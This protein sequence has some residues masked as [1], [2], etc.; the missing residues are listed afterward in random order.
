MAQEAPA[1]APAPAATFSDA[2]VA[3]FA[4]A[5]VKVQVITQQARTQMMQ[6]IESTEGLSIDTYNNIVAAAQKDPAL[7]EKISQLMRDY[8][9]DAGIS[10]GETG[11]E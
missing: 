5:A 4:K 11:T 9:K 8:A 7:A 6:A 2:D 3:S 10:G 1:A